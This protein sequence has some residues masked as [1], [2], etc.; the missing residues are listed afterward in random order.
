MDSEGH[1]DDFIHR[2]ENLD[3]IQN[4]LNKICDCMVINNTKPDRLGYFKILEFRSRLNSFL[5]Q[6]KKYCLIVF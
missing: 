2:L 6:F 4:I 5:F 3:F 1:H